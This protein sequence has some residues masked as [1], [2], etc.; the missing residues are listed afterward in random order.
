[1]KKVLVIL[2]LQEEDRTLF[3]SKAGLDEKEYAVTFR[4]TAAEVSAEELSAANILVGSIPPE[5]LAG[6]DYLEWM[7]GS[8]AGADS[9]TA[10]GVLPEEVILTNAAGAYGI[11]VSEHM[12]AATFALIRRFPQYMRNQAARKWKAMGNILSVEEST[13]LVLGLG[14]IGGRYAKKMK[15]LGAY[16]IGVRRTDKEKPAY[17]DE[18]YTLEH[19]PEIIG[20]A[21]IVAMVLPASKSTEKLMD[22]EML[23][24]MKK[25]SYLVNNGRGN[26]VDI[27]ALKEALDE[28]R[29][30]GAALDVTDPEPLPAEDSLW[31]YENVLLTPHISGNFF[32]RRTLLNVIDL[33]ADNL[34]RYSCAEPLLHVVDRKTGY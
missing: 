7:Q 13:V 12:V 22:R 19:L 11:S 30:A 4:N 26:A 28:G 9:Y 18:Q 16:V 3:L 5:R 33:A 2:P 6:A 34:H 25:G 21:D 31:D 29:L 14:D 8:M 17:V 24:R 10:P 15:A 27:K 23:H 1:M 32:L 20:R